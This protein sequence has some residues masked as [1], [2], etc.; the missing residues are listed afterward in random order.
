RLGRLAVEVVAEDP[1][2]AFLTAVEAGRQGEQRGLAGTVLAE[3]HGELAGPQGQRYRLER[4]ACAEAVP[5]SADLQRSGRVC[6]ARLL[7][8][9]GRR[10]HGMRFPGEGV[11]REPPLPRAGRRSAPT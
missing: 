10:A 2:R 8:D 4:P 5:E 7:G 11:T 9:A 3:Q 1:D 6:A